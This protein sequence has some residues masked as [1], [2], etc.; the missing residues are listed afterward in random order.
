MGNSENGLL[1]TRVLC[2]LVEKETPFYVV[3]SAT[4]SL[5]VCREKADPSFPNCFKTLSIGPTPG[6]EP[7]TSCSAVKHSTRAVTKGDVT[8]D[9]SQQRFL[10]Q[11]NVATLLRDCLK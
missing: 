5:A 1:R 10:A 7:T 2:L 8:G 3:I 6:F 9:D 11:H 4:Q